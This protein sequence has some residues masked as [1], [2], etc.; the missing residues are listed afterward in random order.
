[1]LNVMTRRSKFP[2]TAQFAQI[3]KD[4]VGKSDINPMTSTP[5]QVKAWIQSQPHPF[6]SWADALAATESGYR[7]LTSSTGAK[8]VFQFLPSTIK[9]FQAAPTYALP[10]W[11]DTSLRAQYQ[12]ML[13]H[14]L[15]AGRIAN[16]KPA[17][18]DAAAKNLLLRLEQLGSSFGPEWADTA[19]IFSLYGEGPKVLNAGYEYRNPIRT[20][21]DKLLHIQQSPAAQ[22][23]ASLPRKVVNAPVVGP[24]VPVIVSQHSEPWL[25]PLTLLSEWEALPE[26]IAKVCEAFARRHKSPLVIT[27]IKSSYTGQPREKPS[28]V[29]AGTHST[30]LAVDVTSPHQLLRLTDPKTKHLAPRFDKSPKIMRLAKEVCAEVQSSVPSASIIVE[31]DHI[32]LDAV[33]SLGAISQPTMAPTYDNSGR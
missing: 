9:L 7:V 26:S 16:S 8:G 21:R 10:Q 32:H 28:A 3:I 23:D 13:A 18:A 6:S 5:S 1:M 12:F 15:E 14:L 24:S 11:D 31:G 20:Y 17:Q 2:S 33:H 19:L 4:M 29:A 27:S 25:C 30:H 22:G